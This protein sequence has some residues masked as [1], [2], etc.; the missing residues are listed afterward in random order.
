[1][2]P[3]GIW[4]ALAVGL[5]CAAVFFVWRFARLTHQLPGATQA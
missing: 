5:A 2:G 3:V 1:M 4:A